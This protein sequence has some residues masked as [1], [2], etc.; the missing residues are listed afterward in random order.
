MLTLIKEASEKKKKLHLQIYC[1][2]IHLRIAVGNLP[3]LSM[4]GRKM[5]DRT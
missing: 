3:S 1:C 2:E 4:F 5:R